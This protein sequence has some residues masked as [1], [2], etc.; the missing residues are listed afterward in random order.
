MILGFGMGRG[1]RSGEITRYIFLYGLF[2]VEICMKMRRRLERG[3]KETF[4]LSRGRRK[5]FLMSCEEDRHFQRHRQWTW[6]GWRA[7]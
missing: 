2:L 5:I 3:V 1:E 6:D 7:I 4:F